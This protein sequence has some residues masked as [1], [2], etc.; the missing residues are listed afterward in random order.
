[1]KLTLSIFSFLL[2]FSLFAQAKKI[3]MNSIADCDGAVNIFKS[4]KYSIQF[5]GVAGAKNEFSNYPSLIS[6]SDLNT[7]WVAFIPEY[8]GILS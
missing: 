7:A 2:T 3:E 5:T 8:D 1:M 6:V 4:G